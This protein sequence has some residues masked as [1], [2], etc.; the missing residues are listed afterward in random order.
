MPSPAL[1]GPHP[2]GAKRAVVAPA[3]L[4]PRANGLLGWSESSPRDFQPVTGPDS[5]ISGHAGPCALPT[6]HDFSIQNALS[7]PTPPPPPPQIYNHTL[8]LP[9]HRSL[10]S[11]GLVFSCAVGSW[12]PTP[13][14]SWMHRGHTRPAGHAADDGR[15][16][17]GAAWP[18]SGTRLPAG[19]NPA[20]ICSYRVSKN[21]PG[22]G[23][24]WQGPWLPLPRVGEGGTELAG[25]G[26][27]LARRPRQQGAVAAGAATGPEGR[28]P[29]ARVPQPPGE[30]H[31][32]LTDALKTDLG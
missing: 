9:P 31:A 2:C 18:G 4:D 27:P 26:L 19:P 20:L 24:V 10:S 21:S 8:P 30:A 29:P 32:A 14:G 16:A 1:P 3:K 6:H 23:G 28:S 12:K 25:G 17:P 15:V 13:L 22:A 11:L 7:I 5:D